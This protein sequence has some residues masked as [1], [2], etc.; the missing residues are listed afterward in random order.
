MGSIGSLNPFGSSEEVDSTGRPVIQDPTVLI[1]RLESVVP[2]PALRGLILRATAIAATEG[3]HTAQFVAQN[4]GL[5]DENGIVTFEFR[6]IPPASPGRVG[7]EQ[8]RRIVA[9]TF[10]PDNDLVGIRGF[11]VIARTNTVNLRR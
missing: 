9:A 3:Y 1:E 7:P 8:T 4:E 6:A 2:E 10:I 11:A 5:P